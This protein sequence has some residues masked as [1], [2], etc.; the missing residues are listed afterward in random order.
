MGKRRLTHLKSLRLNDDNCNPINAWN[1]HEIT[2]DSEFN[3]E[4]ANCEALNLSIGSHQIYVLHLLNEFFTCGNYT[5]HR[6]QK[7]NVAFLSFFRC[8]LYV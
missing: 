1:N 8:T 4:N 6:L 5:I 3:F 2:F 7:H